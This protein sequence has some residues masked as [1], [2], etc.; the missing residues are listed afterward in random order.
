MH[1]RLTLWAFSSLTELGNT[2]KRSE[3]INDKSWHADQIPEQTNCNQ[4]H[5]I[6]NR[7]GAVR[8][9]LERRIKRHPLPNN[10]QHSAAVPQQERAPLPSQP[11]LEIGSLFPS[12]RQVMDHAAGD[13]AEAVQPSVL[14]KAAAVLATTSQQRRNI[15]NNLALLERPDRESSIFDLLTSMDKDKWVLFLVIN[16]NDFRYRFQWM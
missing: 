5:F 15:D 13:V 3:W 7:G 8:C 6:S 2:Y 10:L 14:S 4:K 16:S 11:V 9:G 1:V 12:L